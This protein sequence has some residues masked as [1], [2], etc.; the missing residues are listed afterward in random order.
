MPERFSL[1]MNNS[2]PMPEAASDERPLSRKER[3]ARNGKQAQQIQSKIRDS[4]R[5]SVPPAK[6]QNYRRG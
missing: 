1:P 2:E 6:H 4:G 3:R 5:A